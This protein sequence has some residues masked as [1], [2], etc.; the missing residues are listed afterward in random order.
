[1]PLE[2]PS[3]VPSGKARRV[4]TPR[5]LALGR[6]LRAR[7]MALDF[8][9]L[10]PSARAGRVLTPRSLTLGRALRARRMAVDVPNL[11]GHGPRRTC[12]WHLAPAIHARKNAVRAKHVA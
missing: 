1:M 6:A 4:L 5:S 9:S 7:R 2:F 10:A 11:R 3:L 12:V 8:P